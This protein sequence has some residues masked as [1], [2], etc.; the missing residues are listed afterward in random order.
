MNTA[1]LI[2]TETS[3]HGTFGLFTYPAVGYESFVAEPPWR[4][5]QR[6]ISCI[7]AG[8]YIVQ[9]RQSPKYGWCFHVTGVDGRSWILNHSGNF[10]GDTTKGLRS[11][12][13]GCLLHGQ[14]L[15]YLAGQRA[16]LNSRV[17]IGELVRKTNLQPFKLKILWLS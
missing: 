8:E 2:R 3:D 17:M 13:M 16:V 5:N 6:G 12:T 9:P 11:H 1:I 15:G 14:K 10:A 7:P 4:D